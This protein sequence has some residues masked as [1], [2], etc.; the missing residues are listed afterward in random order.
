M[1]SRPLYRMLET[2][3]AYAAQELAASGERED[4][5]DGLANYAVREGALATEV[6]SAPR[7]PSG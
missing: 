7:R 4:A 1:A 2:V 6:S 3:R 5:L